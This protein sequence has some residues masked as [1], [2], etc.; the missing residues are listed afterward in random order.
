M[1]VSVTWGYGQ[2]IMCKVQEFEPIGNFLLLHS[3]YR[4]NMEM[5]KY[6]TV[7]VSSPPIGE[8]SLP[9]YNHPKMTEKLNRYRT[10]GAR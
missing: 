2:P 3:Q 5:S 4:W 7:Q 1:T 9:L 10:H 8:I 6:D